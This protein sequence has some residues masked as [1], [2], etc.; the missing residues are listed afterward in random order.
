MTALPEHVLRLS[1][2][3]NRSETEIILGP[4]SDQRA[5]IAEEL[6]LT[7]LRKFRF[8]A[9][10]APHGHSDWRLTGDLGA[11]V[12]QDCVVTL[13]PVS[14]RIDETVSRRYLADYVPP[15]GG[16]EVEMPDDD[17]AEPLPA[18]IDLYAVAIEALALA[19][20]PWPRAEGVALEETA[21]AAP[22]IAPMRDEDAKPFAGLAA[23]R[24][25][26]DADTPDE[27]DEK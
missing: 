16:T 10:L 6:G 12:V 1:D 24:D 7:G 18:A 23:L 14:T 26:L 22:G 20:P 17:T 5:A 25:K 13:A 19:L 9:R 27:P 11:T 3:S 2:L 21:F 15:E 8:A 4:S